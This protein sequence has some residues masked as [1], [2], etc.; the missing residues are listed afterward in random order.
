M[1]KRPYPCS[2]EP[3]V[4]PAIPVENRDLR[5]RT[6]RWSSVIDSPRAP[7]QPQPLVSGREAGRARGVGTDR[8]RRILL[9]PTSLL[10][11]QRRS[12]ASV[13]VVAGLAARVLASRGDVGRCIHPSSPEWHHYLAG[14]GRADRAA[15]GLRAG[16][17]RGA[18]HRCSDAAERQVHPRGR[19]GRG[20][21]GGG[22]AARVSD[23]NGGGGGGGGGVRN[24]AYQQPGRGARRG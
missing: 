1:T 9:P 20:P 10:S 19:S 18:R 2:P 22:A 15:A 16:I 11:P 21:Y 12:H 6:G 4:P 13:Q 23:G 3:S 8:E 24:V 14:D 5:T 17:D 7:S